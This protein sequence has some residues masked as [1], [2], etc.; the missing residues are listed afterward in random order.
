MKSRIAFQDNSKHIASIGK[1]LI[2]GN[3]IV[4][5]YGATFGTTFIIQ[6][7][8]KVAQLRHESLPLKTVSLVTTYSQAMEWI[9]LRHVHKN[10]HH[11]IN[12]HL[13]QRLEEIAFIRFPANLK[14]KQLLGK[15]YINSLGEIQVYIV[16]ENDPL[17]SHL[18]QKHNI[19]YLAVRSSNLE[20][21]P[22]EFT[23]EGAVKYANEIM[24]SHILFISK[25]NLAA[26]HLRQRVGSQP[27]IR[28]PSHKDNGQI[29]VV[30]SAN[31]HPDAIF[32]LFDGTLNK[33]NFC[34][35]EEKQVSFR[36]PYNPLKELIDPTPE[37]VLKALKIA[38]GLF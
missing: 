28:I 25:Q 29:A 2:N 6:I 12:N 16:P 26:K 9:D 18:K 35:L 14:A 37:S 30:R 20:G 33:D 1:A 22:E 38:S 23:P 5:D 21:Q 10:L 3:P 31:T 13:L 19:N 27:I 11:H 36:N 17:L 34:I 15:N 4:F 32:Q 8:E 24:A 7:R